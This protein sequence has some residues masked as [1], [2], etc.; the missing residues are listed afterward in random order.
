[1]KENSIA[2]L[3]ATYN[4]EQFIEEQ[5]ESIIN[6][7]YKNWTLYIRDD[8][9]LD[10]TVELVKFYSQNN[11]NIILFDDENKHIGAG[12]SFMEMLKCIDAELYMFCDQDDVWLPNKIEITLNKYKTLSISKQAIVIHTDVTVVDKELNILAESYWRHVN[13]NPDKINKYEFLCVCC[14]TNGNTMLFNKAA[15]DLCFPLPKEIIMHDWYVSAQ[16]LQHKGIVEALHIPTVLYRQHDKNV[17]GFKTGSENSLLNHIKRLPEV[18]LNNLKSYRL[19]KD[20]NISILT[21]IYYK[22][23]VIIHMH[24]FSNYTNQYK[25]SNK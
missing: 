24:L 3:M 4:G 1:M 12:H 18:F 9:S 20:K 5:I 25:L 17:C 16:V 15:R 21:Y 11:D 14:Y 13:L 19:L 6:Q 23:L 7:T 2:I 22:V 10:N 8:G